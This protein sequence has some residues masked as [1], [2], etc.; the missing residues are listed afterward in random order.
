MKGAKSNYFLE[1]LM[2]VKIGSIVTESVSW[3]KVGIFYIDM[4]D[5]VVM[6]VSSSKLYAPL[7]QQFVQIVH[8]EKH[9]TT[10]LQLE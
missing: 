9:L 6:V 8:H 4:Q 10:K 2:C 7:S 5:D 3:R 1:G